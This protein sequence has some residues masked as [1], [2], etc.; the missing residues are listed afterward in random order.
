MGGL[1]AAFA[2]GWEAGLPPKSLRDAIDSMEEALE[3]DKAELA[4]ATARVNQYDNDW[5]SRRQSLVEEF[6]RERQKKS[7]AARQENAGIEAALRAD[8]NTAQVF[9]TVQQ[10]LAQNESARS[11]NAISSVRHRVT[12][13]A[14][15]M[16]PS[17]GAKAQLTTYVN[18]WA[19]VLVNKL[20]LEA[21]S[22]DQLRAQIQPDYRKVRNDAESL[23]TRVRQQDEQLGKLRAQA[24]YKPE[25]MIAGW[26]VGIF[27]FIFTVWLF[28]LLIEAVSL[29]VHVADDVRKIREAGEKNLQQA[30]VQA[31][32]AGSIT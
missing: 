19:T 8:Y 21:M 2:G 23:G 16:A 12:G 11:A 24:R 9:E 6:R 14:E 18:N 5:N 17:E 10:F 22:E 15:R 29:S 25:L 7:D 28:G 4:A 32:K 30:K 1:A 26:A 27:G 20:Q 31:A 13:F 3:K